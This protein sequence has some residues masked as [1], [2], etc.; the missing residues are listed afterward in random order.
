[1]AASDEDVIRLRRM[2][3]EPKEDTYT[4][5]VLK[6]IIERFPVYDSSNTMLIEE[7]PYWSQTYDLNRAAA[8]IWEEKAA[9]VAC[10]YSVS[11]DNSQYNRNQVYEHY[12]AIAQRYRSKSCPGALRLVTCKRTIRDTLQ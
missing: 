8:E 7:N 5:T 11:A 10:D 1:M 6:D 2:I 9:A 12:M 4:D 3:A